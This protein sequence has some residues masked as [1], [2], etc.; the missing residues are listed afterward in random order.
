MMNIELEL[1]GTEMGT[2]AWIFVKN[3]SKHNLTLIIKIN[4]EIHF[5]Y[6]PKIQTICKKYYSKVV[7]FCRNFKIFSSGFS[8]KS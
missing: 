4:I 8:M 6:Y 5:L 3:L 1:K 2:K 7:S